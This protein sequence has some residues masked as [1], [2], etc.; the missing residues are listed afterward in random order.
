M[1][2]PL[3]IVD[4]RIPIRKQSA[5][6]QG[7]RRF[8]LNFSQ[9]ACDVIR[10]DTLSQWTDTLSLQYRTITDQPGPPFDSRVT[11]VSNPPC[12][13]DVQSHRLTSTYDKR[14]IATRICYPSKRDRGSILS[15]WNCSRPHTVHTSCQYLSTSVD[16]DIFLIIEHVLGGKIM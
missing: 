9:N 8:A 5:V 3:V 12:L 4:K 11:S 15:D 13:S 10:N 1:A 14:T 7:M 16:V 6:A 2:R